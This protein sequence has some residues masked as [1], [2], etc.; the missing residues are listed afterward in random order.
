MKIIKLFWIF[1]LATLSGV[2]NA[3]TVTLTPSSLTLPNVALT[4]NSLS[5]STTGTPNIKINVSGFTCTPL[6][7]DWETIS[8]VPAFS[9]VAVP[10]F[11][12][13][14]TA[15]G[16]S[17]NPPPSTATAANQAT[18]FYYGPGTYVFR[19]CVDAC[20]GYTQRACADITL[21]ALPTANVIPSVTIEDVLELTLPIAATERLDA[22]VA[23]VTDA[24]TFYW[25]QAGGNPMAITLPSPGDAVGNP[26]SMPRPSPPTTSQLDISAITKPGTYN[27]TVNAEDQRGGTNTATETFL[28]KPAT[29]SLG[30]NLTP[31]W[32]PTDTLFA[33]VA[34]ASINGEIT[35]INQYNDKIRYTWSQT[36]GPTAVS[37][38]A[39]AYTATISD[40]PVAT[41]S[42]ASSINLDALAYGTYTFCLTAE[43]EYYPGSP[44]QQCVSFVV[45]PPKSTLD[46]TVTPDA[47]TTTDP[48]SNYTFS[49]KVTGIN[50][51]SD[52]IQTYWR[53][54]S[55]NPTDTISLPFTMASPKLIALGTTEY[56]EKDTLY[57]RIKEGKYE[58]W[59]VAK[60]TYY[61][62]GDSAK[63]SILVEPGK[64]TFALSIDPNAETIITKTPEGFI[65]VLG[66]N[67]QN[68]PFNVR[69][70]VT[71]ISDKTDYV[72]T[73]W[74]M[75]TAFEIA[76]Q[77]LKPTLPN[78]EA[79][80]KQIALASTSDESNVEFTINNCSP[81]TYTLTFVARD[82]FFGLADSVST[83]IIIRQPVSIEPL[84]AFSPNGDGNNDLWQIKNIES[85]PDIGVKII[86]E[87][88]EL[89]FET[90]SV[91]RLP[92]KSWDGIRMD[93]KYA[94]AGAY[95]YEFYDN[96][97]QTKLNVGS[98]VLVR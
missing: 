81:G 59:F 85:F 89:V 4:T 29:S 2:A 25:V 15:F 56:E 69:G 53:A 63:V 78:D 26:V 12:H 93:G 37:L 3:Q 40:I 42:F 1:A 39:P 64:S 31:S 92:Q 71:G 80:Q 20:A 23:D 75:E 62:K 73:Y 32:S 49:G 66:E 45:A 41:T 82:T 67:P 87:R 94:T 58:F 88:G 95:Y 24:F 18:I 47:E 19:L 74:R 77:Q 33:P 28:V 83:T 36:A 98:F 6:R 86:S 7:Y 51:N 96:R 52:V 16:T 5:V 72:R 90:T 22:T 27:Y 61:G 57:T 17:V 44:V 34:S 84:A 76:D 91:A 54:E 10:K 70:S 21:V 11:R 60:D 79:N 68:V 48:Y 8:F 65:F 38:P 43:D 14:G 9:G 50:N 30:I 35:G 97:D 55:T 13:P 46:V